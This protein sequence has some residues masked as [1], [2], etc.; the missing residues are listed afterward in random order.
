MKTW[1]RIMCGYIYEEETG[2]SEHGLAAG[3]S[4][5]EVPD[6]WSAAECGVKKSDF[7]MVGL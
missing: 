7:Q 2:D 3:T 4:R 1:V 5:D 6:N